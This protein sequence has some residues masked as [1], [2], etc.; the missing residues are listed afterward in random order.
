MVASTEKQDDFGSHLRNL[1]IEV[2]LLAQTV[3]N[4]KAALARHQSDMAA[5]NNER[6]F[7]Q[8]SFEDARR[9]FELS[10][11]AAQRHIMMLEGRSGP[12]VPFEGHWPGCHRHHA[13]T[14]YWRWA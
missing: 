1:E 14:G 6:L 12:L 4:L 13:P 9:Y 5:R 2:D 11:E 10:M 3:E 8:L 7:E